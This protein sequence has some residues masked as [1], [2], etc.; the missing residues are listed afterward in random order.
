MSILTNFKSNIILNAKLFLTKIIQQ[1]NL[2]ETKTGETKMKKLF[3]LVLVNA[4]D[5]GITT[6][7]SLS[8]IYHKAIEKGLKLCAPE[9]A[10]VLAGMDNNILGDKEICVMAASTGQ[11]FETFFVYKRNGKVYITKEE[12]LWTDT[13]FCFHK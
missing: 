7:W 9:I 11:K 1:F 4:E 13:L 8:D 6:E 5:L 3:E 12:T 10:N 2:R